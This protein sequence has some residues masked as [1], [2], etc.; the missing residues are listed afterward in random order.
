LNLNK[1][2]RKEKSYL[3][4]NLGCCPYGQYRILD[5]GR[6]L[7]ITDILTQ[8]SCHAVQIPGGSKENPSGQWLP[9]TAGQLFHH[10]NLKVKTV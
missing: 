6:L 4:Y 2:E 1:I 8:T 10:K 5:Q 7:N 9:S 3:L